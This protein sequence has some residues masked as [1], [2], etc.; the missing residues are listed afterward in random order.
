MF[1]TFRLATNCFRLSRVVISFYHVHTV[2]RPHKRTPETDIDVRFLKGIV[3]SEGFTKCCQSNSKLQPQLMMDVLKWSRAMLSMFGFD[4]ECLSME[5]NEASS[6]GLWP[7]VIR[8]TKKVYHYFIVIFMFV[9]GLIIPFNR[10]FVQSDFNKRLLLMAIVFYSL[11]VCGLMIGLNGKIRAAVKEISKIIGYLDGNEISSLQRN[12]KK[13]F[14]IRHV[15][16]TTPALLGS[17]YYFVSPE[18]MNFFGSVFLSSFQRNVH[19]ISYV[20]SYFVLIWTAHFYWSVES[21]AK[22]YAEHSKMVILE[23]LKKS[24]RFS[25]ESHKQGTDHFQAI[26]TSLER[27]FQFMRAVNQ[28]LGI[29]PLIMFA[30]LFADIIVTIS[31]LT[32]FSELRFFSVCAIGICVGNELLQVLQVIRTATKTTGIIEEAVILS[33][34]MATA[35]LPENAPFALIESRQSLRHYLETIRLQSLVPFSALSTF[36]LQPSVILNFFNSVVPFTVMFI[37]TIAQISRDNSHSLNILT[38]NKTKELETH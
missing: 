14:I 4:F 20:L 22:T 2:F 36:T 38:S 12:D 29:I 8:L 9:G 33:E 16:M 24:T 31:F 21:V 15:I 11:S 27:Y 19:F 3:R 32:L 23:I 37:T 7:R 35:P 5:C 17:V 26:M 10:I 13:R 30:C 6:N 1:N 25:F 28:S 18:T 34:K